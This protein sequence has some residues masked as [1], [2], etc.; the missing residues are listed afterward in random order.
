LRALA[1][2]GQTLLSN[3]TFD[4][5]RAALPTHVTLRDLG[6]HRLKDL[7]RPEHVFQLDVAGLPVDFPPLRSLHAFPNNL[8]IQLTSFV[9][10]DRELKEVGSLLAT[11]H[12]LTLTGPGGTGKTRLELQVS[13]GELE[14]FADGVWLVELAPLADPLLIPQ[15]VAGV[16]GA[17]QQGGRPASEVLSDFLKPK[18]RLLLLDN[19]EHLIEECAALT[20]N[21]LRA[22][23]GLK[24]LATSREPLG[25]SGE[26]IYRVPSLDLPDATERGAA[27]ISGHGAIR[28][29]VERAAAVK[30]NFR[31]T[32]GNAASVAQICGR[33]DGI[34]LAIKLAAARVKALSPE[35]IAIRLDDRFRLLTGGS[36]TA[37]PRQQTL[38]A[39]ID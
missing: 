5:V 39:L 20:S 22:C 26:T 15:T 36:R 3:A 37:L 16:L 32:D 17:P 19:C 14:S 1:F 4:L 6:E 8:P 18:K 38:R 11:S 13:A 21:L 29:F 25:I 10:R 31:L 35:Q 34:P 9:G 2:G 7:Q 24:I 23:P 33:L 28:L 27:L 30:P 12:L